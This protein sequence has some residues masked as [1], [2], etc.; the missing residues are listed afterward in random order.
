MIA[1]IIDVSIVLYILIGSFFEC[2][3]RASRRQSNSFE[4]L[5]RSRV[6][7]LNFFS[8]AKVLQNSHP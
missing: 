4:L 7:R 6:S 2:K 5:R 1:A 3:A 8:G